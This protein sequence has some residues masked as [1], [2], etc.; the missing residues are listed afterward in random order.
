M[1]D[2]LSRIA[3]WFHKNHLTLNI[4]KTKFMIF[5]TNH[6]LKNF[7]DF[8]V[9]YKSENID[10]VYEFKYLGIVFDP[11][12]SWGNQIDKISS[13]VSKRIG[14]IRGLK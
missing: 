5:G 14:L 7:S 12:L 4:K 11:L 9:C 1:N 2:N 6:A 13:N 8:S 3:D 10:R